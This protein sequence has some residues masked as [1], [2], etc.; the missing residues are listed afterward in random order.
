MA[1]NKED[2]D[3]LTIEEKDKVTAFLTGNCRIDLEGEN[4]PIGYSITPGTTS[5]GHPMK[6]GEEYRINVKNIANIPQFLDREL[7]EPDTKKRIGGSEAIKAIME[8][9]GFRVGN[10]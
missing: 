10:N 2:W 6:Y 1:L 4:L 8:Y 9:G 7:R 5:G 3:E